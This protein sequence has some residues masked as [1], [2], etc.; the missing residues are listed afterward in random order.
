MRTFLVGEGACQACQQAETQ[1]LGPHP[2]LMTCKHKFHDIDEL[3]VCDQRLP[4]AFGLRL[5]QAR[6]GAVFKCC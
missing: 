3:S 5:K 1:Q 2:E 6:A 4:E